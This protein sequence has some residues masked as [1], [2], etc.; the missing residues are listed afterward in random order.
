MTVLV[1]QWLD[2][3]IIKDMW[4]CYNERHRTTNALEGWHSKLNKSVKK[5]APK[6]LRTYFAFK[7]R[8]AILRQATK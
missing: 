3:D 8:R 6:H 5:A 2:K 1:D 4:N 7:E